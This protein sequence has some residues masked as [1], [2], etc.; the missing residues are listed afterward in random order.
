MLNQKEGRKEQIERDHT[1]AVAASS[2]RTL[3]STITFTLIIAFLSGLFLFHTWNRYQLDAVS[4]AIVLAQS[5]E[6][7]MHPEHIAEFSGS[8]EDAKKPEYIKLKKSMEHLVKITN[9]IH[10]A[11]LLIELNSDI[12]ILI[13]SEPPESPYYSHS[14]HVYTEADKIYRELFRSGRSVLTE[15][16]SDRRGTWISALV[17]VKDLANGKTIAVFGIDYIASEWFSKLWAKMIPD[18]IIAMCILILSFTLLYGWIQHSKVK[19]LSRKLAYDEAL[20]HSIFE[21]APIGIAIVNNDCYVVQPDYSS[22]TIN[23]MF[24][25]ILGRSK[26][27]LAN[28]KWTEI[29]HPDDLSR[30][31]EKFEQ[32]KKG[33]I[34]GYS[35]EKRYLKPDG[36]SVW[37]NITIS[38]LLG[39]PMRN[40]MHICIVEDISERKAAEIAL[41]ESERKQ[42]VLISNLPG[43]SYRCN[44]DREW[45]MQY[46]SDGCYYLTEY[47][48]DRLLGNRD[49]S[50][51]DL[52]APEYRDSLWNEWERILD[53]RELFKYEYEIITSTGKRKWVLEMGQG[54]YNL[55]GEV[56]AL[57]GIIL[58]ISDRKQ[59]ENSLIYI[60]EHDKWTGLYN[61]DYLEIL[62]KNDARKQKTL[63][64][65]IVGVNMTMV[66]LLAAN[67][68]FH[69]TQSIIKKA[70]EILSG[71]S[72][73][74]RLLFKTYENRFVFYLK[75]YINKTELVEF[76]EVII[77]ALEFLLEV[78]RIGCGIGVFEIKPETGE[79]T[80]QIL[81]KLL[82]ASERAINISDNN[83][84]VC[85]YD[86]DLEA[87]VNREG[88]IIQEL[89][90]ATNVD[91]C[92]GLFLQYQ[93]IM[94]LKTN[95]IC[96][97]EALAR[98]RTETLGL[99]SPDEFIP[100][101][102]K[103]KLII[104]MGEKVFVSAFRFL[105]MLKE[106][107][108]DTIRVS[109][110]VSSIQL[111][112]PDF[113]SGLVKTIRNMGINP[114]N[115]GIEITES[116]FTSDYDEINSIISKLKHA[117]LHVAIDDFGTGYSS[118]ARAEELNVNCLKIDKSF[119]NKLLVVT[120][121]KAITGDIISMAHKLGHCVIAEGVEYECQL[122]YLRDHGCDKIQGYLFGRPFH[123][124]A[125]IELLK[126]QSKLVAYSSASH[127]D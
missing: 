79:D 88:E 118:L 8:R 105:N 78:E 98:L 84:G 82:I 52:I 25:K 21:Q 109:I 65:A 7:F 83:F 106:H 29:T 23:P 124:E 93:P 51:N 57:E 19:V 75:E 122:Q 20:Y 53:K 45:T 67:Y 24:E 86:E 5:L 89:S 30:D 11:Y 92:G 91:R 120:Y 27:N 59:M 35:L 101:A 38:S 126:K 37:T 15:P 31:L 50:Y 64:R 60:N 22:Y 4:E 39:V 90:M 40:S 121:D 119:I 77:K 108:Y 42:A 74:S 16:V 13:D 43:L 17:P 110:N 48:P 96:G 32:F 112:S 6:T 56:E 127:C 61:R 100:I 95:S 14:G 62:L 9:P 85:F 94:D 117:G 47:S 125:A 63:R 115:I 71:Y 55:K 99:V 103:T 36:T 18:I 3:V 44:Y 2:R 81:K 72:T 69:Y 73:D 123:E 111:F 34:S 97:F 28:I 76:C 49:L 66:Q 46:V 54:I 68:G 10:F 102:E 113:I 70:A 87:L 1:P 80:D 107:G 104:P 58:D 12:I 26:H 116:V 114:E 41:N 33:E